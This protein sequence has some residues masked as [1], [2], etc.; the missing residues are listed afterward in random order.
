M[1]DKELRCSFCGKSKDEVQ[2][3]I[4][5]QGRVFICDECVLL[6]VEVLGEGGIPIFEE[7]VRII[8][9]RSS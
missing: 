6:C 1:R 5:G 4:V 9:A 2:K 3:L 8:K 7:M